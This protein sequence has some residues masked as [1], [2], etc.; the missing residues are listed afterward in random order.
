MCF[1]FEVKI[2]GNPPPKVLWYKNDVLI[3]PKKGITVVNNEDGNS[4]LT[5]AETYVEDAGVY[6]CEASNSH[7]ICSSSCQLVVHPET[8]GKLPE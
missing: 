5:L 3:L 1:R 6:K 2:D 8:D 7:G 4:I